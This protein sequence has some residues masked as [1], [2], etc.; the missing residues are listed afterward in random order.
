LQWPLEGAVYT[1]SGFGL[2]EDHPGIY[3]YE[4][5]GV[6]CGCHQLRNAPWPLEV[7]RPLDQRSTDIS[8]LTQFTTPKEIRA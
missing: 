7:F 8:A 2:I 6:T 4:L 3:L 1:V 5:N